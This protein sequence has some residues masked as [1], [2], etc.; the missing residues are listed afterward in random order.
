MITEVP[1]ASA[2]KFT[3][4]LNWSILS[5]DTSN[6]DEIDVSVSPLLLEYATPEVGKML[7]VVPTRKDP[8]FRPGFA[9]IIVCTLTPK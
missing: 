9:P 6:I 5:W 2:E 7:K 3:D 4:G 1:G 8:A